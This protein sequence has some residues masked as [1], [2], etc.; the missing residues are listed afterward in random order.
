MAAPAPWFGL[1]LG[2]GSPGGLHLRFQGCG[3][4]QGPS[5]FRMRCRGR[6]VPAHSDYSPSLTAAPGWAP[7]VL[8]VKLRLVSRWR[9]PPFSLG[10]FAVFLLSL[11]SPQVQV[12]SPTARVQ[13]PTHVQCPDHCGGCSMYYRAC[14]ILP[15]PLG[16][17]RSVF[18]MCTT[19][20]LPP[21]LSL[22]SLFP[23]IAWH[24]WLRFCH[25]V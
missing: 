7:R 6:G 3:S 2:R 14:T 1:R 17:H 21:Q 13:R 18:D 12:Q 10:A 5:E 22:P 9:E 15:L 19:S 4:V 20:R 24:C 11:L 16:R 23:S 25:A 8:F